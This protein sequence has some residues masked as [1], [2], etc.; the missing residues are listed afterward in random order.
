[1]AAA[2]AVYGGVDE[3]LFVAT[4]FEMFYAFAKIS[5]YVKSFREKSPDFMISITTLCERNAKAR[6]QLAQYEAQMPLF[7]QRIAEQA[8]KA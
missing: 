1:M 7:R 3:A 2:L 6:E 8:E 5:P 4:Q